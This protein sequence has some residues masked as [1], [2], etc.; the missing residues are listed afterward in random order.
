MKLGAVT[1]LEKADKNLIII[2]KLKAK[3][4]DTYCQKFLTS[5][6]FFW[7]VANFQQ[8]E[9]RIPNAYPVNF[10][11]SLIVTFYLT[12]IADSSHNIARSKAAIF[13]IKRWYFAKNA[14][15]SKI[16]SVMV[17]KGVLYETTYACVLT[18]Q[19]WRF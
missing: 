6:P 16:K 18:C 8:S 11:F 10:T 12:K 17:L 7:F 14:S 15:I 4:D 2:K 1:K 3:F 9:S 19:I 13:S 5:L